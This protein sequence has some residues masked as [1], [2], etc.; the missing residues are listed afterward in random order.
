MANATIFLSNGW[1]QRVGK[2]AGGLSDA[3]EKMMKAK[4]DINC[5]FNIAS[6]DLAGKE[7]SVNLYDVGALDPQTASNLMYELRDEVVQ[8]SWTNGR[9]VDNDEVGVSLGSS[10]LVV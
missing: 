3:L 1:K 6:S 9:M 10:T 5:L 4:Y 7:V 8:F 2:R